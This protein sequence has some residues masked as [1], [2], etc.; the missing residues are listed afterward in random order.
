MPIKLH[1]LELTEPIQPIWGVDGY[2][3]VRILV[4]YHKNTIGWVY[5]HNMGSPVISKENIQ[6]VVVEQIGWDLIPFSL[7][8]LIAP[9]KTEK[10][11]QEPISVIVCTRDRTE[12]LN[13]CLNALLDIEYPEYEIIVV[14]NAPTDKKTAELV[15]GL[16]SVRYI[17]ED[18]PGL[19]WA[20]NHGIE[21]AKY[22]IIAF[23][24]DDT[25]P[26][27]YWLQAIAKA[28]SKADVMAVTGLIAPMELETDAQVY[29]EF[30][31]G[32]MVNG[33]KRWTINPN[34]LKTSQLLWSNAFGAGANMA[35]RRELFSMIGKFDVALDVGTPSRGGGDLEFFHRIV[36]NGYTLVYDPAAF[37]WHSHR[38]DFKSL[39]LQLFDNGC[40]FGAY[41]MTCNRK[42]TV[43]R[44][45]I[46]R[47]VIYDWFYWWIIR[48]LFKPNKHRR[49]L[50]LS[51]LK[52]ALT[53]P[54]AYRKS[55]KLIRAI[56]AD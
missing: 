46:L 34:E 30:V 48:R 8:K 54:F 9:T 1:E 14:D 7:N 16:P 12:R 13:R 50:I 51:E 43:S 49:R 22:E 52:G 37:V 39:R 23:T 28:F 6:T 44:F 5:I 42:R 29:F 10:Y 55:Q 31:Y 32:G 21:E 24:D 19:D 33:T 45:Q 15:E 41:L 18:N 2:E 35:F 4:R 36:A 11:S 53:S 38:R 40:G 3:A 27:R 56:A 17:R 47:F 25:K 26:D 20:R